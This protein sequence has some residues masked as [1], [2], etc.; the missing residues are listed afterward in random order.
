MK[1]SNGINDDGAIMLCEAITKSAIACI[2]NKDKGKDGERFFRSDW[3]KLISGCEDPEKA[4]EA[5]RM[6]RKYQ[7]FRKNHKCLQCKWKKYGKE[8]CKH[9]GNAFDWR[10]MK[11]GMVKCPKEEQDDSE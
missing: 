1:L 7:E 2:I 6:Q 5:A 11:K 8:G 3:G 10:E 9:K 4:I